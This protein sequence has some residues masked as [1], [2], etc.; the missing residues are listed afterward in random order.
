PPRV[1]KFGKLSI[2][3]YSAMLINQ[4]RMTV[5]RVLPPETRRLQGP[6]IDHVNLEIGHPESY[7]CALKYNI[8]LRL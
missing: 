3:Y 4:S 5:T 7:G 8:I 1:C 6:E 2:R